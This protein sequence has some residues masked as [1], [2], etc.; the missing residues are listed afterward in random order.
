VAPSFRKKVGTNFA[1][2][3]RSVGRYNSLADWGHGVFFSLPM[4]LL[5][6]YLCQVPHLKGVCCFWFVAF[7]AEMVSTA[8]DTIWGETAK[9]SFMTEVFT[10]VG[11]KWIQYSPPCVH[12]IGRVLLYSLCYEH[13]CK[14]WVR[15]HPA[16]ALRLTRSIVLRYVA[17]S[18]FTVYVI[19]YRVK[20]RE[21]FCCRL[22][23]H[24]FRLSCFTWIAR[25]SV[26][27]SLSTISDL[28][29][30]VVCSGIALCS[31][32]C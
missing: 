27:N 8:F 9:L 24:G 14:R 10:S 17:C 11:L 25:Y 13:V 3:W 16:L 2:K 1:G 18:L 15:I 31:A 5:T 20:N 22:S 32:V 6:R 28:T 7:T 29:S 4:N 19:T 26:F 30:W 21:F 12:W 23:L